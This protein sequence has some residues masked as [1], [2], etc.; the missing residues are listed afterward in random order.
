MRNNPLALKF[1]QNDPSASGT[2]DIMRLSTNVRRNL[3]REEDEGSVDQ[4]KNAHKKQTPSHSSDMG[5]NDNSA[6]SNNGDDDVK[7]TNKKAILDFG[8]Q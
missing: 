1:A 6:S 8:E 2:V 7:L 3:A 5:T 4:Y